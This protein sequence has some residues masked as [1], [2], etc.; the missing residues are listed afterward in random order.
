MNNK[1][2]LWIITVIALM[3]STPINAQLDNE[4]QNH[5]I[6]SLDMRSRVQ[7]HQGSNNHL[8][9]IM[10]NDL[11]SEANIK[12][13]MISWANYCF[14]HE[15]TT[16]EDYM[17]VQIANKPFMLNDINKIWNSVKNNK[18]IG[19]YYS[20]T[21]IAKPYSLMTMKPEGVIMD[22]NLTNRT[23]LI[24]ISDFKYNGNDDFYD[25][26]RHVSNMTKDQRKEII[27]KVQTVQQNYFCKFMASKEIAG[28]YIDLYEYI[29][30]QQYFSLESIVDF[31]H[32]IVA[33]RTQNGYTFDFE[34]KAYKNDNY[35]LL[36]SKLTLKGLDEEKTY[37]I[38]GNDK[39]SV[40]I[41]YEELENKY[42][43]NLSL[44]IKSWVRLQDGIYNLTVLHPD[45]ENIQGKLGLNRSIP[46]S[47]EESTTI[48][49]GL[50][51]SPN[52][53]FCFSDDQHIAAD[54]GSAIIVL[55]LLIGLIYLILFIIRKS[56]TYTNNDKNKDKYKI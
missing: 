1:L 7:N 22:R 26:L 24:L 40:Y 45:G 55:L 25:E 32:Q 53:M 43:L 3:L 52:W 5:V 19:T 36:T 39:L 27:N 18:F 34:F 8:I 2:L 15:S 4:V 37:S 28:G 13:G 21:S 12:K 10:I 29:P 6:I 9:P 42:D 30:L 54:I 14:N 51:S 16:I 46:V 11:L 38:K 17:D 41:S 50:T 35:E 31:P 23:F 47:I 20:V 48:L 33:Q 56:I 44:D 49:F